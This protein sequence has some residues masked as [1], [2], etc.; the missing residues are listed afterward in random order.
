MEMDKAAE[1]IKELA[2]LRPDERERVY[3]RLRENGASDK[4]IRTVDQLAD[5]RN[6]IAHHMDDIGVFSLVVDWRRKTERTNDNDMDS[7]NCSAGDNSGANSAHYLKN[8]QY[9]E[10]KDTTRL[11]RAIKVVMA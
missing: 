11:V 3:R 8:W 5:A 9:K 7:D 10:T 1:G 4:A 6:E 2:K